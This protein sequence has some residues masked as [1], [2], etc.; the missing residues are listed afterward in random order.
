MS[1]SKL[2]SWMLSVSKPNAEMFSISFGNDGCGIALPGVI[3]SRARPVQPA[4]PEYLT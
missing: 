2:Y 1:P 3:D 4:N